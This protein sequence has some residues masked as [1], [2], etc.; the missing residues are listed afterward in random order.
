MEMLG[1][2]GKDFRDMSKHAIF[3]MQFSN[4]SENGI[5]Y[6]QEEKMLLPDVPKSHEVMHVAGGEGKRDPVAPFSNRV[7]S[8][9][10]FS[11]S[12]GFK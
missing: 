1:F 4:C 2:H 12:R 6:F 9:K 5:R 8:S 7:T 11:C 10:M 3:E